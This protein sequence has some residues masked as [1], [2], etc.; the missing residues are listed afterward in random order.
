MKNKTNNYDNYLEEVSDMF[1][2]A[3]EEDIA[4]WQK[5]WKAEELLMKQANNPISG[6]VYK[7]TNTL[8]LEL[9]QSI[10]GY[11]HNMWMTFKQAKDIGANVKKGELGV[12][13]AFF[14]KIEK[15]QEQNDTDMD[16]KG[17]VKIF[18]KTAVFNISQIENINEKA[19]E[20]IFKN[21]KNILNETTFNDV[22]QC[23]QIINNSD[24]KFR[25]T[26]IDRAYY[27]PKYDKITMPKKIHFKDEAG[28]YSIA[29]HELGHATAH[30]KRLNRDN[31]GAE[32]GNK[33]YAKEELRAEIYSYL[34]AKELKIDYKLENHKGYVKSWGQL[35]EKQDIK[36]AIKDAFKIKKYVKENWL[37]KSH[38]KTKKK[39]MS[40]SR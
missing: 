19:K 33:I 10:E 12:R 8:M 7:G 34:Q 39:D 14:K 11:E 20:K 6:T 38:T 1:L 9:V 4:P 30:K 23:E 17:L 35:L 16:T 5:P 22:E 3:I 13:V 40:N 27:S 31:F 2:K 26:S 36:E 28:Y 32:F 21:N 18:K 24:V 25:F 15:E 29:L 37:E